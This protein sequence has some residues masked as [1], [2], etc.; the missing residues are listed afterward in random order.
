MTTTAVT[1]TAPRRRRVPAPP[2]ATRRARFATLARRR[3][4]LSARTPREILVPLLTPDPVRPRHRARA[5]Q[6]GG[7]PRRGRHRLHE[8]RRRRHGR[9]ARAAELHVRRHRRDRR[10]RERRAR[11]TC[12]PPR[13]RARCMVFGNLAVALAVSALQV[14]VADRRRVLARR[15]LP[16]STPRGV[17]VVRRRRA[18]VR[19]RHVRRRRDPRQPHRRRRRS[20]SAPRRPIAIVPWFFAG[21]LFPL[22]VL[23]AGLAAF[24]KV[25]PLTHALALMRYGLVDRTARPARHLGHE[26]H[27]RDGRAEPRRRRRVRGRADRRGHQGVQPRHGPVT[28]SRLS[29]SV[30]L[31]LPRSTT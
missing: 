19:D 13:S 4:A 18:A 2:A 1:V 26:Q 7:G 6:D 14:V 24:A 21:S 31:P 22:H 9:P 25:L 5:G 3:F 20:T 12:S 8:L 29:T 27:H 16:T 10:P 30:P 23:P 15:R 28:A 11:A 17:A